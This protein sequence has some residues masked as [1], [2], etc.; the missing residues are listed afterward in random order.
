MG[1]IKRLGEKKYLVMYDVP[2]SG[3]RLRRQKTKTLTGVTKP[4]AEAM[5]AKL[6]EAAWNGDYV[7]N[8][9]MK[10]NEL[11]DI[12]MEAKRR[13]LEATT[14]CR[15]ESF[16]RH[17]LRPQFGALKLKALKKAHIAAALII[18]EGRENEPGGRTLHHVFDLLRATLNWAISM[19]LVQNNVAA[20]FDRSDLPKANR[21][22]PAALEE[23]ELQRL[24]V[25]ARNPT[26]RAEQRGTLSS[27]PWFYAAIVFAVYTG[28]RRGEVLA[29]HWKDIDFAAE[30]V[31]I[32]RSLMHLGQRLE[33][34][35]PKNDRSRTITLSKSVLAVLREHREAQNRERSALGVAYKEQDLVF[36]R[37]DGSPVT[38][39]NFGA[40]FTDLVKRAG[41]KR[42][43]LHDLRDTH[44]SL[45]AKAS[46]PIEVVSQRLGHSSIGITVQRYLTVYKSRDAA[47]AEAFEDIVG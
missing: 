23:D 46:V 1:Y 20:R 35:K 4:E 15:Y 32:R 22:E 25:E 45:L 26:K 44:A 39:W 36:A 38:P 31:T 29:L 43:R 13:R 8:P 12:F 19:D 9:D 34:K 10:M 3:T 47:A 5:L 41:V 27:E 7:A 16:L 28:A 24:L 2:P 17:Y 21:P 40:A 30:A 14:L 33:F 18:W 6:K 37:P 42:I 11:F